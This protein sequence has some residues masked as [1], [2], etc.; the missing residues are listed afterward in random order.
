MQCVTAFCSDDSAQFTDGSKI[1]S[2]WHR[3]KM[4]GRILG[5]TTGVEL[6]GLDAGKHDFIAKLGQPPTDPELAPLLNSAHR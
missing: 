3:S 6:S 2:R 4:Q 5:L 1:E